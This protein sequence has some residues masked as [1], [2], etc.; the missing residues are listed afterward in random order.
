MRLRY[1]AGEDVGNGF[2]ARCSCKQESETVKSK[3]LFALVL[4]STVMFQT[5]AQTLINVLVDGGNPVPPSGAT[6]IGSVGDVWNYFPKSSCRAHGGGVVTNATTVKD[7]TGATPSG[8]NM[9]T[10]LSAD[11]GLSTFAD[12]TSFSPTPLLI[13]GNYVHES[14]GVNY[15]TFSFN[16]LPASRPY[17][18][19]GMGKVNALGQGTAWRADVANGRATANDTN[20]SRDATLAS[21]QRICW[22]KMSATTPDDRA[23]DGIS[24]GV[25]AAYPAAL[26]TDHMP[27]YR[28][29]LISNICVCAQS[30]R[31]AGLIWS[32]NGKR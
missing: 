7:F 29:I 22:V 4:A 19:Y 15:W 16:G 17:M 3:K 24:P 26:V 28:H 9:A 27:H 8:V 14:A 23:L 25:V 13:V 11:A 1:G 10:A 12:T 30:V 32:A 21:N 20:G 6:V 31:A 18:I 2:L 5:N